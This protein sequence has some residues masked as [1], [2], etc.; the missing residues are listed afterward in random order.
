MNATTPIGDLRLIALS[1]LHLS[2]LNTRQSVTEAEIAAMADSIALCGLLQNLIGLDRDGRIEIVGGGKRLRALKVLRAQGFMPR[3]GQQLDPVPV[4][5]TDDEDKAVAWSGAENTARTEL[6]PADEIESYATLQARGSSVSMIAATFAVSEAHVQR[7]LRLARLPE[8]VLANLRAGT[9][10]IDQARALTVAQSDRQCVDLLRQ[11]IDNRWSPDQIRASLTRDMI[12]A[13]DRRVLFVGIDAYRDA[14]GTLTEDLFTD[15]AMLHDAALLNRLFTEK[16]RATAQT[17]ADDEGWCRAVFKGEAYYDWSWVTGLD[18]LTA[19]TADLPAADAEEFQRLEELE[20]L[21]DE[22]MARF[23]E[24]E[25]RMIPVWSDADKARGV[26][27]CYV[28]RNGAFQVI[29]GHGDPVATNDDEMPIAGTGTGPAKAET[30]PQNLRDDLR[31]IRLRAIQTALFTRHELLLDCLAFS[32]AA[33]CKPWDRPLAITTTDQKATPEK[34]DGLNPD[35]RFDDAPM[36]HADDTA[37]AFAAFQAKGRK[38][39]ND[40]LTHALARAWCRADGPMADVIADLV[41]PDIRAIWTPTA[42]AYL[43][44]IPASMLDALWADLTPA[45]DIDPDR[46]VF[47][48]FK[49]AEKAKRLEALFMD[50]DVRETMGLSREQNKAIDTWLPPELRFGAGDEVPG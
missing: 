7:R 32:L 26:I 9:L 35:G 48:G 3:P 27:F 24:L 30:I 10:S 34:T 44:R 50:M 38:H 5:V 12:R 18:R 37:E 42:A 22:E 15:R 6:S 8:P 4:L 29:R 2:P 28:D 31:A 40:V 13:D 36:K 33:E 19:E 39:R 1:D 25:A 20:D 45:S 21:N 49:K 23:E 41:D 14:G 11:V 47:A 46:T 17:I 43:G 16:G